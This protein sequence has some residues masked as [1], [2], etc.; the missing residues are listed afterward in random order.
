MKFRILVL[1]LAFVYIF[2]GTADADYAT[3]DQD[4]YLTIPCVQYDGVPYRLGLKYNAS[5]SNP[6]P[7]YWKYV[8]LGPG[9]E[10]EQCISMD[11]SLKLSIPYLK[12]NNATYRLEL[13]YEADL[14]HKT[15]THYWGLDTIEPAMPGAQQLA[16]E[17]TGQIT[18]PLE[19]YKKVVHELAMIR[20]AYPELQDCE[21]SLSWANSL[22]ILFDR[23]ET[24]V[25][26]QSDI[27]GN[28]KYFNELHNVKIEEIT[29]M[30]P[31][32]MLGYQYFVLRFGMNYYNLNILK[33]KY[34]EL[35][36]VQWVGLNHSTYIGCFGPPC[37]V[38]L[39]IEDETHYYLF[40]GCVVYTPSSE[41]FEKVGFKVS[42]TG[43]IMPIDLTGLDNQDDKPSWYEDCMYWLYCTCSRNAPE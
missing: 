42:P 39:A 31:T 2:T 17:A 37:D 41:G 5:L 36:Y 8:S 35:P 27:H 15:S 3:A 43:D 22:I 18:A 38:C 30:T 34:M 29:K 11:N 6:A 23:T 25:A 12:H 4:L 16:V 26:I 19:T 21:P 28:W 32:P 10:D 9:D 14:V 40:Q 13:E 24:G 20:S 1:S 7:I 33:E